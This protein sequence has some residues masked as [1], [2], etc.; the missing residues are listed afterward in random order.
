MKSSKEPAL[1]KNHTGFQKVV[2]RSIRHQSHEFHSYPATFLHG[3][4]LAWEAS[5]SWCGQGQKLHPELPVCTEK[6]EKEIS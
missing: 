2:L 1:V 5:P 4:I 6:V 3:R